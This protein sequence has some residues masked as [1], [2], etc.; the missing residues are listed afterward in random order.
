VLLI[1]LVLI[2]TLI[3][4]VAEGRLARAEGVGAG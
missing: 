3:A 1:A 4:R 2:I